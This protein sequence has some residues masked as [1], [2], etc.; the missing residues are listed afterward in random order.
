MRIMFVCRAF[1]HMAGGVERM[2]VAIM[3][4][5][6]TRG[7]LV[8]LL[9]WDCG[10][11][12]PF[13]PL[14]KDINWY[15]LNM[16]D[17]ACKASW[18]LRLR[19]LW[20]IRAYIHSCQPQ[21]IIG[22]QAGAFMCARIASIATGIPVVAAERNS[23]S[24]L[25]F[26][27]EGRRSGL[28]FGALRFASAITIQFEDYRN[29]YPSYLRKK[30]R[31]I[32]NPVLPRLTTFL[33]KREHMILSIGRLSFQKNF[34]TLIAAFAQLKDEFPE[35][36]LLI[37]GEGEEREKLERLISNLNLQH[38]IMLPGK[39]ATIQPLYDS[40]SIFCLPSL[41]EGFPN[42]LA[43]A[44][45]SGLPAIGFAE[46]D[47]VR[48]LIKHEENGLLAEGSRNV[49]ALAQA[50]RRLMTDKD[51]RKQ[52]SLKAPEIIRNYPQQKA[53][54]AWETLFLEFNHQEH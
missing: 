34:T 33:P 7:H 1:D 17:P 43:E 15:R 45:S 48:Q 54:D 6:V 53:F 10:T 51:L 9:T 21:V 24:R 30:I 44:L 13:Y 25:K 18:Q 50:L 32:H 12:A 20:A 28:L 41:W 16:G 46:C 37:I 47:G 29:Q 26:T 38:C 19:R 36:R 23:P 39:S 35:W 5:L 27:S 14:H 52:L 8:S 22:F 40:A 42:A 11:P 31:T 4:E 2:A 3:N 49:D